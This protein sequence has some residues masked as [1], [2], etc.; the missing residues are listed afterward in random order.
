LVEGNE[1]QEE[2]ESTFFSPAGKEKEG[3]TISLTQKLALPPKF[4][5]LAFLSSLDRGEGRGKKSF[6]C[7]HRKKKMGHLYHVLEGKGE[8]GTLSEE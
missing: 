8:K 5:L 7:Y 4:T 3:E 6:L 2:H 1:A